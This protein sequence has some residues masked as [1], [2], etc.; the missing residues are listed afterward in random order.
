MFPLPVA[1]I[2]AQ[3]GL[4]GA[5]TPLKV[6]HEGASV[7]QAPQKRLQLGHSGRQLPGN[8]LLQRFAAELVLLVTEY[9]AQ[10]R[11]LPLEKPAFPD[12]DEESRK[13]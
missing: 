9:H 12:V 1:P 4:D 5:Y 3:Q 2:S 10:Q 13:H 11:Q 8:K 6:R 7:V